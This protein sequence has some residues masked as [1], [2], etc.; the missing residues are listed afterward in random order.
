VSLSI[1]DVTNNCITILKTTPLVRAGEGFSVPK[2]IPSSALI[3]QKDERIFLKLYVTERILNAGKLE[4]TSVDLFTNYSGRIFEVEQTGVKQLVLVGFSNDFDFD[5]FSTSLPFL[6]YIPPS[7]QDNPEVHRKL[8]PKLYSKTK[9]NDIPFFYKD[10]SAYPYSWDWLYF[11]FFVNMH[12]LSHQLKKANKPYV[13][14][15]PMIKSFSDGMGLL[16]SGAVLEQCLLGIQ[17]F[18]L[19]KKLKPGTD[20]SKGLDHVTFASFSIG[21][22]IL[23]NFILRNRQ[24]SFFREKVKDFII[25]DP[26][27][28]NPK[29]RSPIINSIISIMRTDGKKTVLLYTQDPYYIQP[30]IKAF[31][32]PRGISFNLS[33]DKIFSDPK[34][35][36]VFFAYLE[37]PLFLKSIQ[38]PILKNVHNT[39][40]NLF[41]NNAVSRG[42]LKFVPADGKLRPILSFLSWVPTK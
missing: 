1:K 28:R 15:V 11:Q 4:I 39:F 16:N 23:S 27:P 21:N 36:N 26:P 13:F 19:D 20:R 37:A 34:V 32:I 2:D 40:P 29:N 25:L 6:I 41:I 33:K 7:P 30:L 35:K 14:V 42:S 31:L 22:S 18:Y 12:R 10:T 8:Y 38:D 5:P 3:P 17:K 24:N 9:P